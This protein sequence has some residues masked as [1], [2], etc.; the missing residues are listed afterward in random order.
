MNNVIFSAYGVDIVKRDDDKLYAVYDSGESCSHLV[1][2]EISK[3]ESEKI[4]K[5]EQDAYAVLLNCQAEG[6]F[7]RKYNH[8]QA[9]H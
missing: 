6:R 2:V 8:P 1:E 9:N 4:K 7:Y 5:S 3:E